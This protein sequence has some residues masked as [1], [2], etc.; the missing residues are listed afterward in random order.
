MPKSHLWEKAA[1]WK[2]EYGDIIYLENFG[3]PLVILNSYEATIDLLEKRSVKYSSRPT[4]TMGSELQD[5][6]WLTVFTPYGNRWK[7]YRG[8]IQ[9]AFNTPEVVEYMDVQRQSARLLLSNL[10]RQPNNHNLFI[11]SSVVR[12][13][14][15][16]TYGHEVL[17]AND[18]YVSL[19]EE[20][21]IFAGTAFVPGRF[22]VDIFTW[23]K[24]VP[25]WFPGAEFQKIAQKGLR[26]SHDMRYV[27][28]E[29]SRDKIL[30]GE[31]K[32]SLTSYLVEQ[33]LAESGRL[34]PDNDDLISAVAG[35]VYAG[36]TDTTG[37]VLQTFMLAMT[38]FPEAQKRGQEEIDRVIGRDR[39]P[40]F[41][42]RENLP[43]VDAI[44]KECLRWHQPLPLGVPHLLT[45][46]D[47]YN[48]YFLPA[49]TL[50]AAN[51]WWM[52][53][54]PVE[55]PQPEVF[56]PERF[57]PEPGKRLPMDPSKV[58]FGFGRRICAGK[59]MADS[60]VYITIASIL[61]VFD[62]SMPI[63]EAGNHVHPSAE[64]NTAS[65]VNHPMPFD[66]RIAP[67]SEKAGTLIAQGLD[68]TI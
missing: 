29:N 32:Q 8:P 14:M 5:W 53:H 24:Y 38:L 11:K 12:T 6:S 35:M 55:F 40:D 9:K 20:G 45:E 61:A 2:K 52:M 51:Q 21:T 10:L 37:S 18:P 44:Y 13:I 57:L 47:T 15:L 50:V 28:Y 46:D 16:A 19:V 23:L 30:D 27:P 1:T 22:L 63:D 33:V 7:G 60:S 59:M 17:E 49:G 54:D 34:T 3:V 67:R 4:P 42:D 62:I 41:E 48:G 31:A 68:W 65:V 36:G 56:K 39:L 25:A 43:Y 64:Y 66:C 26:L 58:A